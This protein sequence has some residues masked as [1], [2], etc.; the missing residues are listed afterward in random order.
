MGL[1]S[2]KEVER[3][4]MDMKIGKSPSPDGFTSNFF[5]KCWKIIEKDI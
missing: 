3:T 1:A 2:L 5:Q 4:I